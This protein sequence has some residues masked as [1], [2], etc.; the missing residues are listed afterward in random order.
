MSEDEAGV[1]KYEDVCEDEGVSKNEEGVR[2]MGVI[3]S[4]GEGDVRM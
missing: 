2:I 4:E 3:M 1:S